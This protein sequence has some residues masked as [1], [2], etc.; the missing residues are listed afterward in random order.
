[1]TDAPRDEERASKSERGSEAA[2]PS[3]SRLTPVHILTGLVALG[4]FY[5]ARPVLLPI[6]LSILLTFVLYRSVGFLSD[7]LRLPLSVAAAVPLLGILV[8]AVIGTGAL[9]EPALRWVNQAPQQ[10]ED[11]ERRLREL[12]RPVI[13]M[14]RS[15]ERVQDAVSAEDRPEAQTII[16]SDGSFQ[17]AV[18]SGI[19]ETLVTGFVTLVLLYFV[20]ASGDRLLR[21]SVAVLPTLEQKKL[22]VEV[23]SI[24][25][26]DVSRYLVTITLI[27]L[28][29]GL[30]IGTAMLLVGAPSPFLWGAM[31]TVFNFIPYLGAATG[32]VIV[33]I[34]ALT[35]F[36]D[37]GHTLAMPLVYFSITSL[38]GGFITPAL[39]GRRFTLSPVAVVIALL[40]WGWLWGIPGAFLAVP[41]LTT[42]KII[43]DHYPPLARI[44]TLLER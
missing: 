22:L 38:E 21:K 1:M 40:F 19:R 41:I 4:A 32:T 16:V 30:A 18:L 31:A 20:L 6:V 17:D 26:R 24:A 42:T 35:T 39:L 29:L 36:T 13:E 37:I 34:V 5:L 25:K 33:A 11:I 44:G 12:M 14:N 15:V 23:A 10:F 9:S 8:A 3:I 43:C 7:T 2:A 27:N 28:A